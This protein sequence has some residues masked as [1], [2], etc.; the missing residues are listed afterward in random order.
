MLSGLKKRALLAVAFGFCLS[1]HGG[2]NAQNPAEAFSVAPPSELVTRPL[3]GVP[4]NPSPAVSPPN[5]APA[6]QDSAQPP[7]KPLPEPVTPAAV[8]PGRV[9]M[10]LLLPMR[11][12]T[13]G[14]AAHAVRAGFLAAHERE[15]QGVEVTLIETGDAAD[16]VLGGYRRASAAHD[17]VVG[18]LT[19]SG[20]T[21]LARSGE[22]MR[23]TIALTT[24][25]FAEGGNVPMPGLMLAVG[26]S[27]EDEARQVAQWAARNQA[28]NT[29]YVVHTPVTWQR[30][31]ARA[32]AER[33]KAGGMPVQLVE[34]PL[35][36]GFLNA[37]ALQALRTRLDGTG[38]AFLFAALDAGQARQLRESVGRQF[39]LYG[40]SQLNPVALPDRATAEPLPEMEGAFLVDLPWQL[41]PDHPAVAAYPRMPV[42]DEQR[43]SADLERLY[44]LGI[45]AYRVARE[46]AAQ[47]TRFELDGVTGRL[48]V[49]FDRSGPQ[50]QRTVTQAVYRDGLAVPEDGTP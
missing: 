40:T 15:P 23:P 49:R 8:I 28:G 38:S 24:P 33:W 2:A 36:S 4:S 31:A 47:H 5:P 11:S 20:V 3:D 30:R 50:F 18:P 35:T 1:L 22:V 25:D 26:L 37:N 44:A 7:A 17:I 16:A 9:R 48:Q 21:A 27:I 10:A 6:Q 39:P 19:R 32:F 45:D 13:L 43:R 42:E 12:A 29:A 34:L 14:R 41:Q 46:L